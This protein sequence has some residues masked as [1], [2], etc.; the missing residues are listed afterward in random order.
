VHFDGLPEHQDIELPSDEE[1]DTISDETLDPAEM[2]ADRFW[3]NPTEPSETHED[4]RPIW[5]YHYVP[6]GS[7]PSWS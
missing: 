5:N 3:R 7:K 2:F 4:G 1:I 6:Y